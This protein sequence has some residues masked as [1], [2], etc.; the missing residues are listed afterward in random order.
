MSKQNSLSDFLK[1]LADTIRDVDGST[2]LIDPQDFSD[3]VRAIGSTG[4][5]ESGV[6]IEVAELPEATAETVG[7][8]Y[9]ADAKVAPEVGQ[10]VGDKLY[11]DTSKNP[12]DYSLGSAIIMGETQEGVHCTYVDFFALQGITGMGHC[13]AIGVATPDM[14]VFLGMPYV[15]CD[16]LTVEQFN[17]NVGASLGL[18]ITEFGWQ[19][20]VVD[21]TSIKDLKITGVYEA[22]DFVK[23]KGGEYY[24]GITNNTFRLGK[25]VGDKIYFDTTKDPKDYVAF[26]DRC[27]IEVSN[28][29]NT[30]TM[31]LVD[32]LA[33]Q[34]ITDYGHCY[35]IGL[36]S[37]DMSSI[38]GIAYIYCDVLNVEQFN[39]MVGAQFG[40]SITQF[41]WQ[42]NVIDT[43]AV[44]DYEVTYNYLNLWDFL[45]YGNTWYD[46]E[47]A[48]I[49]EIDKL[50]G[51]NTTLTTAN[52]TLTSEK[53]NLE[54]QVYLLTSEK[55]YLQ[56]QVSTLSIEKSN[57]QSQVT[58]LT[59]ERDAFR[60]DG[61]ASYEYDLTDE[62]DPFMFA[63]RNI[64]NITIG[65]NVKTI[66]EGA[67]Y[68]S[69]CGVINLGNGVTEIG[70][71]AFGCCNWLSSITIPAGVTTLP[72][73][74]F[75]GVY[76]TGNGADGTLM[77]LKSVL[78]AENSQLTRIEAFV[79]ERCQLLPSIELPSGV[80]YIGTNVF[81][82][83]LALENLTIK[84]T[85]PP[86]LGYS[87]FYNCPKLT[88]IYVPAESVDAYKSA[89]GWSEY[90]DIIQAIAE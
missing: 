4:G 21:I 74:A 35:V 1:D 83:C 42:T 23:V 13:Y 71:A 49:D 55:S 90:A 38:L 56:T 22:Y 87:I 45:A 2:A 26:M 30:Y 20:D 32:I 15:Y 76:L 24:V 8:V 75:S 66:G 59:N 64:Y 51:E 39:T 65:D 29:T 28:G 18:S 31:A 68:A 40:V 53:L 50:T 57:L 41:G 72:Y 58:T 62:I 7:K 78:F 48:H 10:V 44:A 27:L 60:G 33:A 6:P 9:L 84:A 37:P 86:T 81:Y 46:F 19:T 70:N 36:S 34:G 47:K 67:F 89:T 5:G 12:L 25:P 17:A 79:F 43:S 82:N 16:V 69:N 3:R 77:N 11:F 80:T 54:S 61:V 14:S 88:A 63:G 85:T 52:E 73:K